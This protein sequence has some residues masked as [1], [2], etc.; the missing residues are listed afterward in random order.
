MITRQKARQLRAMIEKAS[1][2]L[3]DEDALE[4]IELFP[5]WDETAE[6]SVGDRVRYG[7]LLYK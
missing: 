3:T 6:Y 5:K 7:E 4:A 2:S 1:V